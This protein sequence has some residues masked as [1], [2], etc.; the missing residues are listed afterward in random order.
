[1]YWMLGVIGTLPLAGCA[2]DGTN[3]SPEPT[4]SAQD[5]IM[6]AAARIQASPHVAGSYTLRA[7]GNDTIDTIFQAFEAFA[8]QNDLVWVFKYDHSGLTD[9]ERS[10]RYAKQRADFE[11]VAGLAGTPAAGALVAVPLRAY[12]PAQYEPDST[13]PKFPPLRQKLAGT[14][15]LVETAPR[16]LDDVL[17]FDESNQI[18]AID[19]SLG[20]SGRSWDWKLATPLA[21]AA[22][23]GLPSVAFDTRPYFDND[24][25][26][27]GGDIHGVS[28]G[29]TK[30]FALDGRPDV[31]HATHFVY[32][33]AALGADDFFVSV[34]FFDYDA[35]ADPDVK[36]D[37]FS[38]NLNHRERD[39]ANESE[40]QYL[41]RYDTTFMQAGFEE[42]LMQWSRGL[43]DEYEYAKHRYDGHRYREFGVDGPKAQKLRILAGAAGAPRLYR[44]ALPFTPE[45]MSQYYIN[46][47]VGDGVI[48]IAP[49]DLQRIQF[50]FYVTP[51]DGL[52]ELQQKP[53]IEYQR[54]LSLSQYFN[55]TT[56]APFDPSSADYLGKERVQGAVGNQAYFVSDPGNVGRLSI[57]PVE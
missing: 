43:V 38:N 45:F 8:K 19:F 6:D 54:L 23:A 53:I 36:P 55:D 20:P 28:G 3:E 56:G 1:M 14:G 13:N 52:T 42:T 49:G 11:R 4:S 12:D 40:A 21:P 17:D 44:V 34:E 48:N 22:P 51:K 10:A 31:T 16:A 33:V 30:Q 9:A 7:R 5:S 46:T 15:L 35:S 39:W 37:G 50:V 27:W 32:Y 41:E 47:G 24:H 2:L 26:E 57:T 29:I 18:A 25:P